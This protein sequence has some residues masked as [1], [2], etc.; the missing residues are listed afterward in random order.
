MFPLHEKEDPTDKT[1]YSSIS[2]LTLLSK[3]FEKVAYE[4]LYVYLNNYL[5]GLLC[6]F[7]KAYST[8]NAF[9]DQF[10]HGKKS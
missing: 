5:N 7:C 10:S 3:V 9:L 1:N 4:Q 2:I 8:Q 6:G